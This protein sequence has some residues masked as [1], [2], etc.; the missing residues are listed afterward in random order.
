SNIFY[1]NLKLDSVL[2]PFNPNKIVVNQNV[3]D[4]SKEVLILLYK[5]SDQKILKQVINSLNQA[6]LLAI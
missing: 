4:L 3:Q 2:S 1:D 5:N 6:K